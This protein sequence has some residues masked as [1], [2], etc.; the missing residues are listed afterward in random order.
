METSKY[1]DFERAIYPQDKIAK[2]KQ[3]QSYIDHNDAKAKDYLVLTFGEKNGAV[4]EQH[5]EDMRKHSDLANSLR[6]QLSEII[7]KEL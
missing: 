4:V 7:R 2:I 1:T 3:L 6:S 5:Y